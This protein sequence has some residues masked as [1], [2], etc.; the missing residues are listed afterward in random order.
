MRERQGAVGNLV[1]VTSL[2]TALSPALGG[3]V[4]SVLSWRDLF[5]ACGILTCIPALLLYRLPQPRMADAPA[6]GYRT[7]LAPFRVVLRARRA[8]AID[9]LV[10]VEG[11]L[12]SGIAYLGA[13]LHDGYGAGYAR[14]GLIIGLYGVG[15]LVTAR[16]IGRIA[17]RAPSNR[18]VLGGAAL[19]AASYLSLLGAPNQA[20]FAASML[21]MGAGFVLCHSTLQT[22]ITEA[23]PGLRATAVALFAFSL[24]L[25]QGAGTAA[26]GAVLNAYGYGAVLV[27][28]GTGL[29]IFA[30]AGSFVMRTMVE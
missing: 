6:R 14:I 8:I 5:I 28:C 22:R 11:G 29:A 20:W 12:T 7:L 1:T 2:A 9:V 15:T 3:V 13:L 19:L 25:G 10:F 23:V 27:V 4:A 30:I 26:L 16:F 24:F 17:R 21:V 18:L